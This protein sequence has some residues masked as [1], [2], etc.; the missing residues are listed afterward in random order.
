MKET[1]A[2]FSP[3]KQYRYNLWR[4]WGDASPAVFI[5][6]NPSTADETKNDPTVERCERRARMMGF[7]GL[8]V[9]NIFALRSTDPKLLYLHEDPIGEQNDKA[10]IES[11]TGAGIVVCGWGGHGKLN[12]RGNDVLSL[13]RDAGV[14][15]YCLQI[16]KN[17]TPKHPLYTGYNVEPKEWK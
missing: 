14:T 13:I 5:M 9:A 8:R 2:I 6:L 7:G 16:N 10:I 11:I 12:N 15:P 1:G 17:K 3:C 4:I